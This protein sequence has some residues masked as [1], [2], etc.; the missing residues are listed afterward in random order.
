MP[1]GVVRWDDA[2]ACMSYVA[3]GRVGDDGTATMTYTDNTAYD[4][5][6]LNACFY[7]D[8]YDVYQSS[9]DFGCC[10]DVV[11]LA[12]TTVRLSPSDDAVAQTGKPVTLTAKVTAA[13]GSVPQGV[14]RW[15]DA[16]ACM[17]YVAEG[18]GR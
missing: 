3:E 4:T 12:T 13:D 17:S 2:G 7:P 14:V 16:G 6:S 9:E 1:Q 8:D 11:R 15:D 18:R 10:L 5:Y